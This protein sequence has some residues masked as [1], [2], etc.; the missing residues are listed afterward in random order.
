M[1]GQRNVAASVRARLTD[2]ARANKENVQLI[3]TRYAIERLLYRL[4]RS[5]HR[6]RFVLKGAMLFSLWAPV[7][8][9]ATGDLDLLGFGRNDAV[10]LTDTF[11]DIC[12]IDV[13]EDGVQFLAETVKA[14]PVREDEEYQGIRVTV[15]ALIAGARI[16]VQ[17]DIGFGDAVTPAPQEIEYPTLLDFPAPRLRA[18]PPE[19]V[20]AEKFQAVVEL[21]ML[22]SRMKD[23]YDLWAIS[24]TFGFDGAVLAAAIQATFARR[25]TALPEGT[26]VALTSAFATTPAKQSQW[27]GFIR[28]TAIAM[29]PD[30]FAAVLDKVEAFV[31]PPTRAVRAGTP[32]LL[33]WLPG[34]PWG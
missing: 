8:Y 14:E 15:V 17:I 34:G 21:G 1:T 5:P 16:S 18:Y 30:S 23:F 9:R 11:R 13:A 19:T 10:D 7:P 26:P 29:E 33:R 20:V 32:F 6:D 22:N 3:L 4:S 28:R 25:A 31:M 27:Q 24:T 2:R 12:A